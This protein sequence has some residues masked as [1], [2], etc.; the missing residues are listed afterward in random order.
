MS[1]MTKILALA[2][3]RVVETINEAKA[4]SPVAQQMFLEHLRQ[5][6]ADPN[7]PAAKRAVAALIG[8]G[9]TVDFKTKKN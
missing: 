1:K 6:Q 8:V 9:M 2:T 7:Q 4:A 3:A 5:V